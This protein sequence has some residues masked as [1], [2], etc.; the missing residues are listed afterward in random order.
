MSEPEDLVLANDE[1]A[2]FRLCRAGPHSQAQ[3]LA[4]RDNVRYSGSIERL[5]L[6]E[7]NDAKSVV[8]FEVGPAGLKS[9]VN[10]LPLD[11]TP[12]YEM[13]IVSPQD[14]LATLAERF[15]TPSAIW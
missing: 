5:D 4:G 7:Q 2:R 11:A 10:L 14:Q 15:P 13:A 3:F 9:K 8:V 6:G 1:I 12:I